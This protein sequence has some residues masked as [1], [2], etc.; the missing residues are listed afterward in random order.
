VF[1]ILPVTDWKSLKRLWEDELR[2][3]A[4]TLAMLRKQF[5]KSE[6]CVK[7]LKP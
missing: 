2:P 1:A 5:R 7:P 6:E 4:P 3:I